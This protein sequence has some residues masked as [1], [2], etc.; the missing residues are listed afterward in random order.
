MEETTRELAVQAL[1]DSLIAISYYANRRPKCTEEFR[2]NSEHIRSLSQAIVDIH[3]V[4]LDAPKEVAGFVVDTQNQPID[5]VDALI[6]E[7]EHYRNA[8]SQSL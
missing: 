4:A 2:T 1:K 3:H 6:K 5:C 7:A 8:K